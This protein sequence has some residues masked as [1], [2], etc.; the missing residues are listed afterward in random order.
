MAAYLKRM[1]EVVLGRKLFAYAESGGIGP[2][3][4]RPGDLVCILFGCSVPVILGDYDPISKTYTLIGECYVHA[5]M[6]GEH[7]WGLD[8]ESIA[9]Q[10]S[11]FKIR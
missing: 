9:K 7:F 10:T 5:K 3:D 11:A 4:M 8:Q 2:I 6:E 1:E